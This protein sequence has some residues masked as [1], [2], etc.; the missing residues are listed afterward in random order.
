VIGG[1]LDLARGNPEQRLAV[2]DEAGQPR[3]RY[4]RA[5]GPD[6]RLPSCDI[7]AHSPR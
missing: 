6:R 1:D 2:D 5:L 4:T 3:R 7:P